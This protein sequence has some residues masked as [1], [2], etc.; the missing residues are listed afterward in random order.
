[1]QSNVRRFGGQGLTFIDF[2]NVDHT[3]TITLSQAI[4]NSS[5]DV[6]AIQDLE[7]EANVLFGNIQGTVVGLRYYTGVVSPTTQVCSVQ[8]LR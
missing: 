1:M 7:N 2:L 8:L 3:E 6:S 5:E 4:R